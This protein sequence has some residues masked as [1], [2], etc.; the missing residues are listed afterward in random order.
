VAVAVLASLAVS[1]N[2]VWLFWT[3]LMSHT[4][5]RKASTTDVFVTHLS[6]G[7]LLTGLCGTMVSVADR[8]F[9]GVYFNA[10]ASWQESDLCSA[11]G[12]MSVTAHNVSVTVTFW[13]TLERCLVIVPKFHQ[14]CFVPDGHM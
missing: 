4:N 14:K 5:N 3:F 1:S 6:A 12:V 7:D 2:V 13:V 8:V 10:Q 11:I 9:D